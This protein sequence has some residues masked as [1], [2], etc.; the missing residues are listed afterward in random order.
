MERPGASN[1]RHD[2]GRAQRTA[3]PL[4]LPDLIV[5]FYGEITEI[6]SERER[7]REREGSFVAVIFIWVFEEIACISVYLLVSRFY[8]HL[9]YLSFIYDDFILNKNILEH[10]CGTALHSSKWA[11][12]WKKSLGVDFLLVLLP[13]LKILTHSQ[14]HRHPVPYLGIS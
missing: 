2:T 7:E 3:G 12:A 8:F 14:A 4:A 10:C 6:Q 11:G 5:S 1:T 13:F 9:Y